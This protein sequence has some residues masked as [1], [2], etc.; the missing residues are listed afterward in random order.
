MLEVLAPH[1]AAAFQNARL[2]EAERDAAQAAGALLQLSQ[3]LT[4]RQTL[5][6]IFRDAIETLPT[7]LPCVAIG[8]LRA[9]RGDRRA[10]AW[11]SSTGTA[12][13]SLRAR[14]D[15]ADVPDAL[16]ERAAPERRR[17][18]RDPAR[19]RGADAAASIW[20]L[21]GDFGDVLVCPLRWEPEQSRRADR[22][23]GARRVEP[24]DD[25]AL[26]LARGVGDLTALALGNARRISELERF[27]RLVESLDAI[28]WEADADDLDLTFLGGRLD[29]LFAD[30]DARWIGPRLGRPHRGRRPLAWPWPRCGARSPTERDV[31]VEYRVRTA[32]QAT[33]C[34]CATSSTSCARSAGHPAGPR[35][36]RRHHRAQ[37]GRTDAPRIRAQVLRGVPA[38]AR[39]GGTAP[40]ARRDEEHVPRGR[41]A[42]PAHAAHVDPRLGAHARA[43]P[44]R[45]CRPRR[46]RSTWCTGSRRTPASSSGCS[47]TCWTST[48]CS[49][50]S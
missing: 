36:H 47:A 18:V 32:R 48:A 2:L 50:A 33:P 37:A 5:G 16:A 30:D 35:A 12:G 28:F 14:A 29:A 7:I 42:R 27:H 6:D 20:L 40:R 26:R 39:G 11:R 24:F 10:S 23:R 25:A 9:R 1:A 44:P 49:A 41:V 21:D 22:G 43:E 46:R 13:T 17:A 45:S 19:R 15:I 34:G 38:R 4:A 31:S 3:S 8:R